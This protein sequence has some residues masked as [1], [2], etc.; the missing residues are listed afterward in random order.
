[1]RNVAQITPQESHLSERPHFLQRAGQNII[2]G[3]DYFCGVVKALPAAIYM[4]DTAGLITFYN[5]AAAAFWGHRPEL[6]KSEWCGSWKLFWPDGRPMAHDECPMA[7]SVREQR[8]VRGAEAIAERPD[9]S[10][11]R[12]APFPT[13]LRDASGQLVGAVNMLIDITEREELLEAARAEAVYRERAHQDE[14][15]LAAIIE[16]SD[17]AIISEDLNGIITSWNQGAERLFGYKNV[18]IVGK[19][20]NT[21]IPDDRRDEEP[22]I[23]GRL[24]HGEHVDHFETVRRHKDGSLIDI[25]MT[26]SPI[27]D[28]TGRIIGASE[29]ARDI[30][31][32]KRAQERQNLIVNEMKHRVRNTLTTVQAVAGQTLQGI[33]AGERQAF[34]A[35]L[36]ALATAHDVLTQK[37][38]NRARLSDLVNGALGI[39]QDGKSPRVFIEGPAEV[40][41]DASKSSLLTMVFH[42][43]GTNAVKYGALSNDQGQV[44]ITWKALR[45]NGAELVRLDWRETGGPPVAAPSRKGFGS[46]LVERALQGE[47]GKTQ[48]KFDPQGFACTLE[49]SI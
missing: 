45:D 26:I 2:L 9:G 28:I 29:V 39:F 11:I 32:R 40:W 43:L 20:I 37:N 34:N 22:L 12:F 27:R 47:K 42:E 18:E 4:T 46:F 30:S 6:G 35:R 15:R 10:R 19:S 23:L 41:F 21:M 13:L 44:H 8:E 16:S 49:F 33:S 17:D 31:E 24:Q 48:M 25:S 5:E 7:I 36:R 1:M 3:D 14:Q 38:W